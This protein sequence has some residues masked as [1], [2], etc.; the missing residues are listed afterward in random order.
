[1]LSPT[2][3]TVMQK[4]FPTRFYIRRLLKAKSVE[5]MTAL[6]MHIKSL[7]NLVAHFEVGMCCI[8]IK[9]TQQRS[10]GS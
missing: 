8:R 5:R 10:Q 2:Q 6:R 3:C 1:M 7:N 4:L 9:K